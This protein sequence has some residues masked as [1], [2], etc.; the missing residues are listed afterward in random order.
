MTNVEQ[1][2]PGPARIQPAGC[3]AG[4]RFGSLCLVARDPVFDGME[5]KIGPC[6]DVYDKVDEN[7]H[8]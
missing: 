1:N 6:D 3:G 7:S 5:G 2:L 8:P 4:T